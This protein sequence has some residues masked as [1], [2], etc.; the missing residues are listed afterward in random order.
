MIKPTPQ[1]LAYDRID[2]LMDDPKTV[3]FKLYEAID[4][5]NELVAWANK[6]E[7]KLRGDFAQ[8]ERRLK[9]LE[10]ARVNAVA[11][12]LDLRGRDK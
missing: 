11:T 5:I 12:P 2:G 3:W 4:K 7:T 9:E 10:Y 1:I 6:Q 8:V